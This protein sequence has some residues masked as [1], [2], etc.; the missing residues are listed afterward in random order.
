MGCACSSLDEAAMRAQDEAYM[1]GVE[2]GR[3]RTWTE[4]NGGLTNPQTFR[5]PLLARIAMPE[6]RRGAVVIGP[7]EQ[8]VVVRPGV[9]EERPVSASVVIP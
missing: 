8:V 1:L 5:G 4:L 2:A 3:Q 7:S 9:W 6:R